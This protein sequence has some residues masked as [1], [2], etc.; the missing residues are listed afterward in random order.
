[1]NTIDITLPT[2]DGYTL[3]G[4]LYEYPSQPKAVVQFNIGTGMRKEFYAN[5]ARY[6]AENGFIVCL[7]EYRG[8]GRSRPLLKEE[9]T[10][11]TMQDWAIDMRA[12]LDFLDTR[13]PDWPKLMIGHSI[14]GQ[15]LGLLPNH[16][17]LKGMLM[18]NSSTGT[19][20]HHTLP[21]RF[22]SYYFFNVLTPLLVPFA[23][24]LPAK[25]LR[26]ME[27]LPGGLI[28]EWREWC[29]S[30]N[31]LFDFL[32][33]S[34]GQHFYGDIQ[35]PIKAY[36]TTD[37][38]I[39]NAVTVPALLRHFRKADIMTEAVRPADLATKRLGHFGL[40]SRK[41]KAGFWT[42]AVAD[43]EA[44]VSKNAPYNNPALKKI[45]L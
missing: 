31:Y 45:N 16:Q 27:D 13:Y 41:M 35:M 9:F 40:F 29:N 10:C 37:D 22:K 11:I 33:K 39:A 43:L 4:I 17:K 3:S 15:L 5:F 8:M 30:E 32:G 12:V 42:K 25:R 36:W 14:G 44:M 7:W 2:P 28:L 24:Y 23:G 21:Y 19:W 20:W 38:P 26:I 1:M 6:L 34:I 18:L